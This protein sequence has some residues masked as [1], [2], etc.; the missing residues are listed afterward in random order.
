MIEALLIGPYPYYISIYGAIV[1][2]ISDMDQST[3]IL[4]TEKIG[5]DLE[6]G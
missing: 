3:F 4:C 2:L 6:V 5:L 1:A